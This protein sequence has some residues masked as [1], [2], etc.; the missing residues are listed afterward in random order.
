MLNGVDPVASL[1][2]VLANIVAYAVNQVDDF[3]TVGVQSLISK[4]GGVQIGTAAG[5][6]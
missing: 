5:V 2:C 1:R 4:E 6:Q 3:P